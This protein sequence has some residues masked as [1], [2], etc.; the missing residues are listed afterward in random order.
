MEVTNDNTK[1]NKTAHQKPSTVNPSKKPAANSIIKTL[2]TSKKKPSVT[3]VIG[4]VSITNTGLIVALNKPNNK[5]TIIPVKKESTD[6][7]G[8]MY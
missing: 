4:N 2:I 7:P 5:A 3:T 6:T 8:I 1:L